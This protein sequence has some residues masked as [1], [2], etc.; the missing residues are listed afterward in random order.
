M[1]F[2]IQY[3]F[4]QDFFRFME[5]QLKLK[6]VELQGKYLKEEIPNSSSKFFFL[7]EK[8]AETSQWKMARKIDHKE[9]A[10]ENCHWRRLN[11]ANYCT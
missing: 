3:G 8:K 7:Y 9:L 4:S 1:N 6:N 2:F 11:G 10:A 5:Y